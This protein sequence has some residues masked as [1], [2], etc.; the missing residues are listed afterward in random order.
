MPYGYLGTQPNQTVVNTGVLS[1]SEAAKLQSQGKLGGS[2][3][4]IEEQTA[5][6]SATLDF[7]NLGNYD[8]HLFTG[9]N[10]NMS[11]NNQFFRAR[12]S[13]DGG[14]SFITTSNHR[15]GGMR[16]LSTGSFGENKSTTDTFFGHYLTDNSG[17]YGTTAD[18]GNFYLYCYS[19][20]DSSQYSY[21]TSQSTGLEQSS[22]TFSSM[23]GGGMLPTAETHNAVRFL[24]GSTGTF[25]GVIKCYGVKQI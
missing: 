2:L 18:N 22:S 3:E 16:M 12:L 9:H 15:R 4:L 5:S 14:S 24:N 23:F 8:V 13:N 11:A 7:T 25:D 1:V 10:I 20:L 19:L 17:G 21:C 6:A